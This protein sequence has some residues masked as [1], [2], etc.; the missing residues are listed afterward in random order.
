MKNNSKYSELKSSYEQLVI[1]YKDCINL[2]SEINQKW[3]KQINILKK[4]QQH[5]NWRFSHRKV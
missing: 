4:K 2:L 5:Y 3:N 1:D